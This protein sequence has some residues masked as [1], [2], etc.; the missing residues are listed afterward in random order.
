MRI[1]VVTGTSTGVG[2]TVATAALFSHLDAAGRTVA[3]VKPAQTGTAEAEPTDAET[4]TRLSGSSAVAELVSLADPL[5]PDSAA[6]LR[7]LS[8][9][10]VGEL[11]A[12]AAERFPG[13]DVLLIEGAGGVLV[14]LDTD[15]G[16]LVD[17]ADALVTAGHDVRFVVVTTVALGTLNHT[18]L[19]VGLLRARGHDVAGLILG[20]VPGE[21]GL[22]ETCN[23]DDLTRVTELPLLA[24]LPSGAG[25]LTPTEFRA[26]CAQ[27]FA[28]GAI[29]AL[30]GT[31]KPAGETA[32]S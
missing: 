22:A 20:S 10:A 25:A 18:E 23:V 8:I 4:V 30:T 5:A 9:P 12:Q 28:P 27:W 16:T 26:G 6:R 19:T 15:G 7:D 3:M 1:V 2:K 24:E 29:A 14:R 11:A 17:L 21:L 32:T 31:P 13:R